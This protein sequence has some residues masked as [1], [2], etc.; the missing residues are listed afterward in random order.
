MYTQI[1]IQFAPSILDNDENPVGESVEYF[2]EIQTPSS[3]RPG[4]LQSIPERI[5]LPISMKG[6]L[7]LKLLPSDRY[8]P[9]GR[10]AVSYYKKSSRFPIHQETWIVPTLFETRSVR[11]PKHP[12]E[13]P[14]DFYALVS[15]EP[16]VPYEIKHNQLVVLTQ[17]TEE[18]RTEY[19]LLT[20]RPAATRDQ[21][22]DR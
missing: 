12:Y 9:I 14:P 21:L 15:L 20:Y 18:L 22:I 10:Y 16:S 2:I 13:L 3:S 11:I 19:L 4:T 1:V 6:R 7:E 8:F 5:R 17:D